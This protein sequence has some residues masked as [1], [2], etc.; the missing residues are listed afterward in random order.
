MK[1]VREEIG[2]GDGISLSGDW[3]F[4]GRL[5]KLGQWGVR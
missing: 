1:F 2:R 5:S 3:L 4:S